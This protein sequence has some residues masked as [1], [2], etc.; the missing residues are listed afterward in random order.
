MAGGFV[1]I[2]TTAIVDG[3]R[4]ALTR[5]MVE[6]APGVYVG[7]L[8]ERV[9]K[10]LWGG[11]CSSI[12]AQGG[13]AVLIHNAPTEQGF[14]VLTHGEGTR[15]PREIDGFALIG[16]PLSESLEVKNL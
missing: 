5:W 2:A 12:D 4:G 3:T 13:W 6:P 11:L 9:W 1:A 15:R 16:W 7:T 10:E 8:T 14:S